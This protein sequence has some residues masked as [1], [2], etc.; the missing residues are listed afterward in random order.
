MTL[1]IPSLVLI[2]SA[3]SIASMAIFFSFMIGVVVGTIIH[4]IGAPCLRKRPNPLP[5]HAADPHYWVIEDSGGN[6]AFTD[7]QIK[8][9]SDR[10]AKM[11]L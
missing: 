1:D 2:P 9:A 4:I 7:E 10:A 11:G 8:V 3:L 6:L 5:K